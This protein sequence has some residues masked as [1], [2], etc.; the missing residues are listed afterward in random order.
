MG[1]NAVNPFELPPPLLNTVILLSSGVTITF[2]HHSLIQG[3]RS[4]ALNGILGTV[5]LAVVFAG[6][7]GVEYYVSSF[8]ISDGIFGSCFFL[9][10]AST[11]LFGSYFFFVLVYLDRVFMEYL[12]RVFF[13]R[14]ARV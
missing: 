13:N 4:G 9:Q 5:I 2:A 7:Q 3:N 6:F 11:G 14:V 10:P 12:G 1:F 8:T